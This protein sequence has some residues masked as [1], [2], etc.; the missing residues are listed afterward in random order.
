[1]ITPQIADDLAAEA[2]RGYDLGGAKRR[3]IGH[4]EPKAS[5]ERRTAAG[6]DLASCDDEDLSDD[7]RRAIQAAKQE[8][9]VS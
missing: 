9:A 2:E 5:H 3:R 1:M 7:D 8:A 4:A 6:L